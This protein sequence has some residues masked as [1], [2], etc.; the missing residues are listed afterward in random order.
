MTTNARDEFPDHVKRSLSERVNGLCSRPD[1]RVIT[2][3]ARSGTDQAF[4]IGRACH[5]HAAAKGGPRFLDT[6]SSKERKA[7]ANG[8]WLCA[9]HGAEVDAD[10]SSFSPDT[11]RAWK[12]ETEE[13]VRAM[14][15]RMSSNIPKPTQSEEGL[16]AIGPNVLVFGRIVAHEDRIWQ[17]SLGEFLLGDI[18]DLYQFADAFDS[19]DRSDQ[20]IALERGGFGGLL[21]RAPRVSHDTGLLVS[22]ELVPSAADALVK[23]DVT[24]HHQDMAIDMSL[25]EPI[26]K[27]NRMVSGADAVPQR[28]F[29]ILEK[30]KGGWRPGDACGN[31]IAELNKR[32]AGDHIESI[33]AVEIARLAGVPHFDDIMVKIGRSKP[34]PVLGFVRRVRGV[35]M[36]APRSPLYLMA[37]LSLDVWGLAETQ[38]YDIPIS[39]STESL[40]PKPKLDRALFGP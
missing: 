34:E 5:I 1:C 37:R 11:L 22:V 18:H 29:I 21:T 12:A 38:E 19:V 28:L 32:F 30:T 35:R 33:I 26:L 6:Q 3:G 25:D 14:V 8:V 15:G 17:L 39:S 2:K 13:H 20:Y 24:A 31:R 16:I 23:F 4:T 27:R 40:G 9:I 36:M 7:F 10:D